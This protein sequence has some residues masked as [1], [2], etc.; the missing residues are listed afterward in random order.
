MPDA[1]RPYTFVTRFFYQDYIS[2]WLLLFCVALF[3]TKTSTS[4]WGV[5]IMLLGVPV[6]YLKELKNNLL[7]RSEKR[8]RKK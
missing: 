2:L 3:F 8:E 1:E 6:Y 4:G 7:V 5:L